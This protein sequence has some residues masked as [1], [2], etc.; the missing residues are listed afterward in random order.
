MTEPLS[1]AGVAEHRSAVHIANTVSEH[2]GQVNTDLLATVRAGTEYILVVELH[3]DLKLIGL[4]F[5]IKHS[6][7][8]LL[9][10]RAVLTALSVIVRLAEITAVRTLDV[11]ILRLD[12]PA[13]DQRIKPF[14]RVFHNISPP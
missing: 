3:S 5:H 14:N 1:R 8:L 6:S 4:L 13:A 11:D 10:G 2:T 9:S 7:V 12:Q